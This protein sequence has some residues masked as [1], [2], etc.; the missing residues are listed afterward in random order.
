MIRDALL[1]GKSFNLIHLDTMIK[2]DVFALTSE[3]FARTA[4]QRAKPIEVYL[5]DDFEVLSMSSAEDIILQK[6]MW[7]ELGNRVSE[8]QWLDVLGV[9]K[10][11]GNEL[12]LEYLATWSQKLDIQELLNK[13]LQESQLHENEESDP[14]N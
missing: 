7:Y 11:Q 14:W 8:R 13:A 2:I 6:L 9:L 5:D 4:F 12:D 1:H 10:V 3:P